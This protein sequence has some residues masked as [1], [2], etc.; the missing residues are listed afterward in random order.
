MELD[1]TATLLLWIDCPLWRSDTKPVYVIDSGEYSVCA[2]N[3]SAEPWFKLCWAIMLYTASRVAAV[4]PKSYITTLSS[5]HVG[6]NDTHLISAADMQYTPR[7]NIKQ[8]AASNFVTRAIVPWLNCELLRLTLRKGKQRECPCI[9]RAKP[10]TS[11]YV[12]S[13]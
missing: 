2:P 4:K 13:C 10:N 6:C 11:S 8:H 3:I 1:P 12:H 5:T 9:S 7:V